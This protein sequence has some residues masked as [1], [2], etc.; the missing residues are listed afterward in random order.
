MFAGESEPIIESLKRARRYFGISLTLAIISLVIWYNK[1]D[2]IYI[3]NFEVVVSIERFRIMA[4]SATIMLLYLAATFL[5]DALHNSEYIQTLKVAAVVSNFPWVISR[6]AG[7]EKNEVKNSIIL[8]I[9]YALHPIT[10]ILL[11]EWSGQPLLLDWILGVVVF[12][13][14]FRL[15]AFS[16][17]FQDPILFNPNDSP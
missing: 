10:Y 8:R 12:A 6:Y 11:Y 15:F 14:S 5:K 3:K 17:R 4:L 1:I 13:L 7:G 16:E 9:I 2:G